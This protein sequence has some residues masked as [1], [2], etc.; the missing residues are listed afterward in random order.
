MRA[1]C[2]G[3]GERSTRVEQRW[4]TR[5]LGFRRSSPHPH[6]LSDL[7][8]IIGT[9]GM[10]QQEQLEE[11]HSQRGRRKEQCSWLAAPV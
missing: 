10:A 6:N 8:V 2:T 1:R 7:D 3:S 9:R 11:Q 4:S 5:M